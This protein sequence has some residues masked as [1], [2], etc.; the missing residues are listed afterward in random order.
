MKLKHH[1]SKGRM[2]AVLQQQVSN[3]A[4]AIAYSASIDSRSTF[5][6]T[7]DTISYIKPG[8]LAS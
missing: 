3:I 7:L 1:H 8:K 6:T 2:V 4:A 5:S